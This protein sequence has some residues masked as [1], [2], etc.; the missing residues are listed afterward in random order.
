ML[1]TR[2]DEAKDEF[3]QFFSEFYGRLIDS[4]TAGLRHWQGTLGTNAPMWMNPSA[5]AQLA[6]AASLALRFR[7]MVDTAFRDLPL[8]TLPI[9][10]AGKIREIQARWKSPYEKLIRE[11]FGLPAPSAIE[12][13]AVQWRSMFGLFAPGPIALP[14]LSNM[15]PVMDWLLPRD[16]G[17]IELLSR[18]W[19]ELYGDYFCRL[20][21][22]PGGFSMPDFHQPLRKV[23]D[24]Q[25]LWLNT[26]AELQ[27]RMVSASGKALERIMSVV[28]GWERTEATAEMYRT[29]CKI[30]LSATEDTYTELFASKE[31]YEA[32]GRTINVGLDAQSTM[33]SAMEEALALWCVPRQ[34]DTPQEDDSIEAMKEQIRNLQVELELIRSRIEE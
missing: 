12:V 16:S 3:S 9:Q 7:D 30:W 1:D 4:W 24:S 23:V 32:V 28:T 34:K 27:E 25:I 26:V 17:I 14:D 22:F 29:F 10:D 33:V 19:K 6:N 2:F 11:M 31:F 21:S 5:A 8:I 20:P 15:F 13:L 18:F